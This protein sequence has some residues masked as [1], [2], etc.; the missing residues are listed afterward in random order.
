M[1]GLNNNYRICFKGKQFEEVKT[2]SKN[3]MEL[4]GLDYKLE[5][6]TN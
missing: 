6:C 3:K 1:N 2:F 4:F 5:S